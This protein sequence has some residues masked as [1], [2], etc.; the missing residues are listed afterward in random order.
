M[1]CKVA[2]L[3]LD[4]SES[5]ESALLLTA[6]IKSARK[7]ELRATPTTVEAHVELLF[8]LCRTADFF[9]KSCQYEA[10]AQQLLCYDLRVQ[11]ADGRGCLFRFATKTVRH[12]RRLHA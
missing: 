9:D 7:S 2:S 4:S 11:Y 3:D 1:A 5:S 8:P 12:R 6:G 10:F